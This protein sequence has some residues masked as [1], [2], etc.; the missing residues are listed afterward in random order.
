MRKCQEQRAQCSLNK[1]LV[2]F[3]SLLAYFIN[4]AQCSAMDEDPDAILEMYH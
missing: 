1:Q 4:M 2:F 3:L